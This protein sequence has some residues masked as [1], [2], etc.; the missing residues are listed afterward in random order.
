MA[1][2]KTRIIVDTKDIDAAKKKAEGLVSKVNAIQKRETAAARKEAAERLRILRKEKQQGLITQKKFSQERLQI[3]KDTANKAVQIERKAAFQIERINKAANKR[4]SDNAKSAGTGISSA[5]SGL[6]AVV[7]GGVIAAAGAQL[8]SVGKAAVKAASDFELAEKGLIGTARA[9]GQSAGEATAAATELAADGLLTFGQAATTL[10]NLIGTG[11]SVSDSLDIAKGLKDVAS[12]NR[13]TDDFASAISESSKGIKTNSIELIE[14]AGLTV[15]L[16]AALQKAGFTT[17][18]LSDKTKGLAAREALRNII[19]KNTAKFQGDAAKFAETFSGAQ[20]RLSASTQKLLISFGQVITEGLQ[21][22]LSVAADVAAKI[23]N[24]VEALKN[25]AAGRAVFTIFFFPLIIV[26]KQVQFVIGFVVGAFQTLLAGVEIF[27]SAVRDIKP[28]NAL[29]SLLL[30]LGKV[31]TD[32][33]LAPFRLLGK[34]LTGLKEIINDPNFAKGARE[35][36]EGMANSILRV[37]AVVKVAGQVLGTFFKIGIQQLAAYGA[38]VTGNFGVAKQLFLDSVN[39]AKDLTR[40]IANFGTN[41]E[42]EFQKLLKNQLKFNKA[43]KTLTEQKKKDEEASTEKKKKGK[44]SD[45]DIELTTQERL[46]DE[47]RFIE[48]RLDI[49]GDGLEQAALLERSFQLDS[50]LEAIAATERLTELEISQFETRRALSV[51]KDRDDRLF[52][53]RKLKFNAT[54]IKAEKVKLNAQAKEQAKFAKF[55]TDLTALATEFAKA[56]FL[57]EG[58]TFQGFIADSIRLFAKFIAQKIQLEAAANIFSNPILALAQI[59]AS[60]AVLAA[61]EG[62]ARAISP[63]ESDQA[64]IDSNFAD[65][66]SGI[67]NISTA[68]PSTGPGSGAATVVQVDNSIN[69]EVTE[70]GTYF[71]ESELIRERINPLIQELDAERGQVTF[72]VR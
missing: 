27:I 57:Q 8:V 9:F 42:G 11:F 61:G 24:I 58:L 40:Q 50:E 49:Q 31:I 59:A 14:N 37:I 45:P 15:R 53:K 63:D 66:I 41:A 1:D 44:A 55:R 46:E 43:S 3:R 38:A 16:G 5:F 36:F 71:T 32:F 22:F 2:L 13:V 70:L 6:K 62:F 33:L 52:L 60:G 10:K 34:A 69:V 12:F 65:T 68:P 20:T 23:T 17:D 29:V 56:A 28:L 48:A 7:T 35:S 72:A 19:L 67:A 30:R 4:L 47:R 64:E 18:D 39:N 51:A 25:T 21:P 54:E 26:L